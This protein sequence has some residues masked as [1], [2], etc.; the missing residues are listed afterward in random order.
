VYLIALA[1]AVASRTADRRKAIAAWG[2][3]AVML[4]FVGLGRIYLGAHW[5]S[6]VLAGYLLGLMW[7]LVIAQIMHAL[8]HREVNAD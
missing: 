2:L 6:D 7:V 8:S 5:L 4:M 1:L 3:S